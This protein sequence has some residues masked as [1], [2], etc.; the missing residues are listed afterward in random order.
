MNSESV[1]RRQSK[2]TMFFYTVRQ[3]QTHKNFKVI[4]TDIRQPSQ[5][6]YTKPLNNTFTQNFFKKQGKEREA[7][8]AEGEERGKGKDGKRKELYNQYF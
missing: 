3:I 5:S 4:L 8:G 2:G 1:K 7:E 6:Y